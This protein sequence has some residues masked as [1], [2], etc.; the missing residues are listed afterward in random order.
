MNGPPVAAL[1]ITPNPSALTRLW[2][3][4]QEASCRRVPRR[5]APPLVGLNGDR[6]YGDATGVAQ[7]RTFTS[8]GT[9][10]VGVRVSDPS[11]SSSE[12]VDFVSV[13]QDKAAGRQLLREPGHAGRR[14]AGD[15]HGDGVGSGSGPSP[16]STGT[17]TATGNSTTARAPS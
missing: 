13:L 5:P 9:Y 15:L 7:T 14:G 16:R 6:T 8:P 11:G 4:T 10:R 12:A 3:S 17:S 2:P 1:T